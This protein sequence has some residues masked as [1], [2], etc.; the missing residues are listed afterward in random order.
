[1]RASILLFRAELDRRLQGWLQQR[2]RGQRSRSLLRELM[3]YAH[4]ASEIL[5][6][7]DEFTFRITHQI[8]HEQ[9]VFQA[10][11]ERYQVAQLV[12]D[13]HQVL[14]ELHYQIADLHN[15]AQ[16]RR[17]RWINFLV[18]FPALYQ[19]W[20][21]IQECWPLLQSLFGIS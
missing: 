18:I 17:L 11:V 12:N 3:R 2:I 20:K 19:A 16:S 10:L 4:S 14:G 15:Q 13:L 6:Q 8:G 5:R 9:A 7:F 1:M 21:L